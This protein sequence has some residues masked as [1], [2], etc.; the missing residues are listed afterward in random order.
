MYA[1]RQR[2]LTWLFLIAMACLNVLAWATDFE[3]H[4][5]ADLQS[6]QLMIAGGWL[7][8]GR[9]HRLA[10]AGV[11]VAVILASAAP[12]YIF[13]AVDRYV[14]W[15]W[16]LGMVIFIAAFTAL[17]CWL[18]LLALGLVQR[19]P[20]ALSV[21]WR[22]SVA[23]ILGWMIIVA[24]AAFG[25]SKAAFPL[26]FEPDDMWVVPGGIALVAALM[27]TLFLR[28]DPQR[29]LASAAAVGGAVIAAVMAI[30]EYEHLEDRI[31][32][33]LSYIVIAL[34]LLVQRLDAGMPEAANASP[35][36]P[37]AVKLFDPDS[38]N[39]RRRG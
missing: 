10:R 25:L 3:L 20:L 6:A 29:D 19:K 21:E 16:V 11:F 2:P 37:D 33:L 35:S 34:W 23:E 15:P 39:E 24:V 32:Q 8:L 27:M 4:W 26:L 36:H 7:A 18:W 30:A 1:F 14:G 22:F 13:G 9:A 17:C 12:D 31:S 38:E 5:Y 28:A